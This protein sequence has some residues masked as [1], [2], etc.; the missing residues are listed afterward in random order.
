MPSEGDFVPI[1]DKSDC[2]SGEIAPDSKLY[3]C[4]HNIGSVLTCGEAF[5]APFCAEV[6]LKTVVLVEI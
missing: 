3:I 5:F 1:S 6:L 2:F 4:L